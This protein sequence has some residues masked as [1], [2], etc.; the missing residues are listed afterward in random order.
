ML[1]SIASLKVIFFLLEGRVRLK[2][3]LKENISEF[4]PLQFP[5]PEAHWQVWLSRKQRGK[6]VV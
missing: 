4:L 3:I 2:K 5:K 6:C 1:S